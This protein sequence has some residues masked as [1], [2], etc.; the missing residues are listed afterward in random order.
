MPDREQVLKVLNT[1]AV[2]LALRESQDLKVIQGPPRVAVGNNGDCLYHL[3]IDLKVHPPKPPLL[4]LESSPQEDL[5]LI[6]GEWLELEDQGPR[7]KGLGKGK[8]RILN[9]GTEKNKISALHI[10]Q[11]KLLL[12]FVKP[13]N[14]VEKEHGPSSRGPPPFRGLLDNFLYLPALGSCCIELNKGRFCL[15]GYYPGESRFAT[16][17]RS[18]KNRG[19]K[20]VFL[21]EL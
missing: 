11:K 17:R 13:V 8:E 1:Y 16:T 10:G 15:L 14:L 6:P 3:I 20:P 18:I 5:E 12:K 7:E 21:N 2:P 19:K 9:G 4:V